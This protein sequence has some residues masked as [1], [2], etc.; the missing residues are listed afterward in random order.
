MSRMTPAEFAA[1]AS[2]I[3]PI[4]PRYDLYAGQGDDLLFGDLGDDVLSGDL[5]ADRY[6]FGVNA[7]N[8]VV[9]GFSFAQGDRLVLGGQTYTLGSAADGF[10]LLTLSGG[11]TVELAGLAA[12]EFNASF[13]A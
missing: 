12:S 7:G 1:V 8:D 9:R 11:G 10:A 3:P 6:V 5:G 2:D 4:M 13:L